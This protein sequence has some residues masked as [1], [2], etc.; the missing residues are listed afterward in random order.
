MEVQR[1][2][3]LRFN[4]FITFLYE[5]MVKVVSAKGF[6]DSRWLRFIL[7]NSRYKIT[8]LVLGESCKSFIS[9]SQCP[10][11]INLGKINRILID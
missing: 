5:K 2:P 10:L 6:N 8:M 11:R 4:A 9:N 7:F 1:N 3:S